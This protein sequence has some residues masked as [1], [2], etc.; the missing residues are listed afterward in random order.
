VLSLLDDN[1]PRKLIID[2][3]DTCVDTLTAFVK[4]LA[5]LQRLK[6]V[7]GNRITNREHLGHWLNIPDD[8]AELWMAEF[9]E[10]SW[11]WGALYP[12]LG[13]EKVLPQ[14]VQEGWVLIAY[15][16]ASK[17]LHR[18]TLRR[19]NLELLFPGVF[20]ELYVVPRNSN[21][22]PLLKEHEYAVCV[23]STE[24]TARSCAQAGH[25]TYMINQPWNVEFSDLSAR[26]FSNWHEIALALAKTTI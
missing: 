12:M 24:S 10:H 22:Y 4:W 2:L 11:Q 3:D 6:N 15:T 13:A 14:L 1:L 5:S 21:L 9:T 26:K 25:A 16:K 7:E 18:A 23:T 20:K 8:L 19:A 17:E